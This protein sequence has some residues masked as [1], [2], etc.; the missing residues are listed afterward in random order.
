[1]T[2]G[3]L[4]NSPPN[5]DVFCWIWNA[6]RDISLQLANLK[7]RFLL[8]YQILRPHWL[9]GAVVWGNASSWCSRTGARLLTLTLRSQE[10]SSPH[11]TTR[12]NCPVL[13]FFFYLGVWHWCWK[14]SVKKTQSRP[15]F[16]AEARGCDPPP[17][18]EPLQPAYPR[19][20]I[21]ASPVLCFEDSLHQTTG[22]FPP[23]A[24]P[25]YCFITIYL[26]FPSLPSYL[27]SS[28]E[29]QICQ[30]N[31]RIKCFVWSARASV[32]W[33]TQP[34]LKCHLKHLISSGMNGAV[35]LAVKQ[36][37]VGRWGPASHLIAGLASG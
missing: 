24:L 10:A 36:R 17:A 6:G 27:L 29:V 13:I 18:A 11:F 25:V 3:L 37:R 14:K 35:L 8:F 34:P 9:F 21:T 1:M 26:L 31:K 15:S 32:K 30:A 7:Q 22:S 5:K 2:V 19:P 16:N 12:S 28:S 4:P 23:R 20:L 33:P